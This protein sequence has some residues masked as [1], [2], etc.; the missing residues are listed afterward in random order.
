MRMVVGSG[1]GSRGIVPLFSSELRPFDEII[2]IA[3]GRVN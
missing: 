1:D 3:S 2:L